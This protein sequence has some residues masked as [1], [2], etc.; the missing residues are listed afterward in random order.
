MGTKCTKFE[1]KRLCRYEDILFCS[2]L[3]FILINFKTQKGDFAG[4]CPIIINW[5]VNVHIKIIAMNKYD[6]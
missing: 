6:K 4:H 5:P 2:K 3:N 1:R